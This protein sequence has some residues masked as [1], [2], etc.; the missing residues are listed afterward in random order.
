MT[1]R[2]LRGLYATLLAA[3]GL[4]QPSGPRG[5]RGG[6]KADV[7]KSGVSPA[8]LIGL[9]GEERPS[10]PMDFLNKDSMSSSKYLKP[11]T[12]PAGHGRCEMERRG[13]G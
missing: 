3:G 9:T 2:K 13:L 11:N 7:C 8:L 1:Q 4:P 10:G 12:A 5:S 6:S